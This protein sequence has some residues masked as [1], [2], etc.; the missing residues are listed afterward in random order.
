MVAFYRARQ[1]G[2]ALGFLIMLPWLCYQM[3]TAPKALQPYPAPS[4]VLKSLGGYTLT[5]PGKQGPTLIVF[6]RPDDTD[7]ERALDI[8]AL[9]YAQDNEAHCWWIGVSSSTRPILELKLSNL[10]YDSKG[11]VLAKFPC[12][13]GALTEWVIVDSNGAVRWCGERSQ[14]DLKAKLT[15]I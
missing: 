12:R 3:Q 2:L 1:I 5:Y 15:A 4:F 8:K 6:S 11:E 14:Q 13:A 7:E 9:K 10:G